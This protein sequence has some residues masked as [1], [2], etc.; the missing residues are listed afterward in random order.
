M[1]MPY[2]RTRPRNE[3]A[4]KASVGRAKP[5]LNSS[6]TGLALLASRPSGVR[7]CVFCSRKTSDSG[8]YLIINGASRSPGTPPITNI[9]CQP[10]PLPRTTSPSSAVSTAP[11]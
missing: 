9:H 4:Q 7:A 5:F 1:F 11:T 6:A 3:L 8:R 2:T 10:W